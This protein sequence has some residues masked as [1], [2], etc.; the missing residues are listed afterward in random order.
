MQLVVAVSYSDSSEEVS[1]RLAEAFGSLGSGSVLQNRVYLSYLDN[2]INGI[3]G[4][5]DSKGII[6]CRSIWD[7]SCRRLSAVLVLD[8]FI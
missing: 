7:V 3:E 1:T 6:P 8:I 4:E 5:R 2:S